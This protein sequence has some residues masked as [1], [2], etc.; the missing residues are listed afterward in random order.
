MLR[1]PEGKILLVRKRGTT[2][3]MNP[4]GKP[5]PGETAKQCAIREVREELGLRLSPEKLR[6]LG[7]HSAPAAN[8][9]GYRV[10]ADC[11]AYLDP[12][13]SPV[14]AAAEIA[15]ILWFDPSDITNHEVAPLFHI[16]FLPELK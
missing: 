13:A 3:F 12:I 4:G 9:S 1:Q 10:R 2:A 15:E 8:E 7:E 5:L 16:A 11:F 6:S 14:T